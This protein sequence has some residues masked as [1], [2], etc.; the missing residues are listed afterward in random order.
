M[1][2]LLTVTTIVRNLDLAERNEI[3]QTIDRLLREHWN[4]IMDWLEKQQERQEQN[5]N[6]GDN[7]TNTPAGG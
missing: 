3:E 7:E 6:N 1:T 5:E 2:I 4:E